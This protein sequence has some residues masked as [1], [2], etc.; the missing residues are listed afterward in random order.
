MRALAVTGNGSTQ[1]LVLTELPIPRPA[2][3]EITIDVDAAGIGLIDAFWATG[4]MPH[5]DG[6]VP[7]LEVAGTVREAGDG[8]A[9]F[10][11]G[12]RIAAILPDAGGFAEVARA[13]AAL[14]APIPDDMTSE[15]AAIVPVNTVT[16]H[17][18]LTT[19]ARFSKGESVL[20]HAAVGGLGSQFGQIARRLGAQRVDAVVG[21]AAKRDMARHL[22]YDNTYLRNNLSRIPQATYDIVVDS[23]G[24]EA[25]ATAFRALRAGGRLIRVGNASQ[26]PDVQLSS[27]AH[28]FENKT[29]AGFNVG[30]WLRAYPGQGTES[31]LWALDAVAA[32]DIRVPLT[33]T[34]PLDECNTLLEPLLRG[35]TTGKLALNVR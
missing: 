9:D 19:V 25:T 5:R 2:A 18:A 17:L 23:V 10:V 16:A 4:F 6:L 12:Q 20:V 21:S 13:S 22:G 3:G 11:P 24:G 33:G 7:G 1:S 34:A 28:W 35:D 32:G 31:L 30:G 26:A 15:Q 29:T 8:V 27:L 14:C